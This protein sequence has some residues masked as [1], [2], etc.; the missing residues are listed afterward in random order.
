MAVIREKRQ[1][2]VG[3]IG[4]ARASEGGRIVGQAISQAADQFASAFYR[5]G[6][7]VAETTGV[8]AGQAAERERIMTINPQTGQ[9]EAYARA[10]SVWS[11]CC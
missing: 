1:F 10:C 6:L 8:E 11:R 4:V 3:Q 7:Q 5:E 9:P 2:Q